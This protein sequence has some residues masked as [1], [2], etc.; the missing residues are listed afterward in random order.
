MNGDVFTQRAGEAQSF[1]EI[2][3]RVLIDL[4]N[5]QPEPQRQDFFAI[6]EKDGWL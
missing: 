1:R 2:L 4:A 3:R 6:L 5:R